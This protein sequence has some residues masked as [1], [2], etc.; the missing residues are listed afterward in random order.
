MFKKISLLLLLLTFLSLFPARPTLAQEPE[1]GLNFDDYMLDLVDYTLPNGLRVVLAEDHSAPVAAIDIWYHVG[2][3]NDPAGRSGFAHMFEHMMFEGSAN[4]PNNQYRS[5][6]EA[7]GADH[8]A[9]T[10]IDK[11]AYWEVSRP[12]SYPGCCGWRATGW[13]R[14]PSPGRR[15]KRSERW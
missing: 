2:G 13:P 1:S 7:V 11:T 9:Y 15:L 14:W 12:M 5:L 4:I 10:D 3:A 8:N 6:L